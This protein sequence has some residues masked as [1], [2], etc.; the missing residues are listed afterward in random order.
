MKFILKILSL[1]VL[2]YCAVWGVMFYKHDAASQRIILT[3]PLP[4]IENVP[5]WERKSE[6]TNTQIKIGIITDTHFDSKRGK[7]E[8]PK[9]QIEGRYIEQK[10]LDILEEFVHKMK[11]F[12]PEFIIHL[13]DIIEGTDTVPEV[14]L[15]E[16]MIVVDK[17]TEIGKPLYWVLGNHD[18]RSLSRRDFQEKVGVGYTNHYFDEG[19]YRFVIIDSNYRDNGMPNNRL[20]TDYIPGHIPETTI[21]WLE[22]ILDTDKNVYIF[23]H[24]TPVTKEFTGKKAIRNHEEILALFEKY[25]VQAVFSGHIEKR[26]HSVVGGVEYYTLPGIKKSKKYP[27]AYYELTIKDQKPELQIYYQESDGGPYTTRPF[28][29]EGKM[30]TDVLREKKENEEDQ[31]NHQE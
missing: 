28:I 10:Y 17:L 11:K 31:S 25:N 24:H 12:D 29:E 5:A 15:F 26:H 7:I 14:G 13:G 3:F 1:V 19:E 18:L 22:K 21:A 20:T 6:R 2:F 23:V 27:G 9:E 16:T 30:I 4:Q 8:A